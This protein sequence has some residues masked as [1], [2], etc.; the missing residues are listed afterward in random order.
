M[1]FFFFFFQAEDGIRDVAVTG[2]Q[3]CALPILTS[4]RGSVARSTRCRRTPAVVLWRNKVAVTASAELSGA[5]ASSRKPDRPFFICV[6]QVC[7]SRAPADSSAWRNG[8]TY[9]GLISSTSVESTTTSPAS[10]T[11]SANRIRSALGYCGGSRCPAPH[12][13]ASTRQFDGGVPADN[14][15]NS[16]AP[17]GVVASPSTGPAL[18]TSRP[19]SRIAV[20]GA[21]TG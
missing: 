20:A 2:V 13:L 19:S 12:P 3:T 1:S 6:G 11:G 17:V 9:S 18:V 14:T 5:I 16:A 4:R 8:S 15:R 7:T 21:G 10:A